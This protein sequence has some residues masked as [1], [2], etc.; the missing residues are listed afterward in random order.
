[1]TLSDYIKILDEKIKASQAQ[2]NIEREAANISA[3]SSGE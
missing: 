1:M 2:Y 3:L